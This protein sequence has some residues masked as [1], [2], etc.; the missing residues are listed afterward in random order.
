MVRGNSC[1]VSA[2]HGST[3][4]QQWGDGLPGVGKAAYGRAGSW[5]GTKKGC[6]RMKQRLCRGIP[7]VSGVD[8]V[9]P[10]GCVWLP[11]LPL[12]LRCHSVLIASHCVPLSSPFT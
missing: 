12:V 1:P 4:Q 2:N 11:V 7:G 6:A 5:V 9:V 3:G 8:E 10:T